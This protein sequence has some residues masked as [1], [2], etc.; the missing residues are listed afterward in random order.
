MRDQT[1]FDLQSGEPFYRIVR[2]FFAQTSRLR[3]L[4]C[5]PAI[6]LA[7]NPGEAL[8]VRQDTNN[9]PRVRACSD[10]DATAN[11]K[12]R[13]PKKHSKTPTPASG[14]AAVCL[15][16]RAPGLEVQERLQQYV[17]KQPWTLSAEDVTEVMWTFQLT[18]TADEV[19]RY[20]TPEAGTEHIDW[21]AG[22]AVIV[23]STFDLND[24]YTRTTIAAHF[25]GSGKSK[26]TFAAQRAFWKWTS[27]GK[28]ETQLGEELRRRF[29]SSP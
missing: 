19:M 9:G 3:G 18:L 11:E 29:A 6:L 21:Q 17:R 28:L 20:A 10:S 27:N 5:V 8:P 22:K 23:I 4:V 24:G 12:T 1:F 25:T 15:E 16:V 26:D 13:K 14:G 2:L 7:F